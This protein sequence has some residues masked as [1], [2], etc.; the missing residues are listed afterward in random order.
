MGHMSLTASDHS[1]L[2]SRCRSAQK[3]LELTGHYIPFVFQTSNFSRQRLGLVANSGNEGN[4]KNDRVPA[5][6][7][8]VI[9]MKEPFRVT[10]GE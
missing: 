1:H 5:G 9:E 2:S 4:I 6:V 10:V 3:P 8:G 7:P